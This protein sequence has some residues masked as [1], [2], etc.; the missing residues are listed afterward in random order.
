[1][2]ERMIAVS[3]FASLFNERGIKNSK[4]SNS[5]CVEFAVVVGYCTFIL[6]C[7]F[8]ANAGWLETAAEEQN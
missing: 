4:R 1:M 5:S 7:R 6:F 8:L 3:Q 2:D